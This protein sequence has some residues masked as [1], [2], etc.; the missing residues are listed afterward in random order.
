MNRFLTRTWG[1]GALV[2]VLT[3]IACQRLSDG[4][5]EKFSAAF[6]CPLDRVEVRARPDLYPG[7]GFKARNPPSEIASDPGRL[8]LW[9][10]QQDQL[11]SYS[12]GYQIYE[13]RGC[14]NQSL[15]ECAT[16]TRS[17][18]TLL[19]KAIRF[20]LRYLPGMAKW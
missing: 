17:S 7:D 10:T 2:L 20:N 9:Q 8:K 1:V 18:N 6:T 19:I 5:K 12:D 16:A 14:G 3:Q 13:A 4:A 11:R 15:Y